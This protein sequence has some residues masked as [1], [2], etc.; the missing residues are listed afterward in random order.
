[1]YV[2]RSGVEFACFWCFIF[3]RTPIWLISHY[4]NSYEHIR[5]RVNVF[6]PQVRQR[7]SQLSLQLVSVAVNLTSHCFRTVATRKG[8]STKVSTREIF[9]SAVG[10][11]CWNKKVGYR[12]ES[13]DRKRP[14]V[15]RTVVAN[16]GQRNA[17]VV[18]LKRSILCRNELFMTR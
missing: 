8:V 17:S 5:M 15:P 12:L 14:S 7:V 10:R 3:D 1:M 18:R 4:K 13:S 6:R 2:F 9:A 16:Y 11:F